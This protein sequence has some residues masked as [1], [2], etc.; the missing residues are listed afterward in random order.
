MDVL[1]IERSDGTP[2]KVTLRRFAGGHEGHKQP[3]PQVVT[4]E[5]ELM[6]LLEAA[7]IAAP[8]PIFLDANGEYLGVPAMVLSYLPGRP[9][10]ATKNLDAWTHGLAAALLR[11]HTV[12]PDRFDLSG[13]NVN[14]RDGMRA[15]IE[16]RRYMKPAD[17]LVAETNNVLEAGLERIDFSAPTL[18]HDDYWPGNKIWYRGRTAGIVDWTT[19][20][21][22]DPRADVAEC[23]MSLV[24]SHP[25]EVADLFSKA[26]ERL[27][28]QPLHDLW[29][30]DLFRGVRALP[31][32]QQWLVGYQD[33]GLG[34][35]QPL[36]VEARLRAFLRRALEEGRH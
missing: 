34:D 25:V 20:E 33:F 1:E 5:F 29:Y 9:L 7:E 11:V 17:P 8:R 35:L 3:S 31:Q 27:A 23:R 14:L 21:V 12:T 6:R 26:Y 24:F 19:A 10:F 22:G 18:V 32:Y 30:F 16:R 36:D 28:G 13:L 15:E 2:W 4:R